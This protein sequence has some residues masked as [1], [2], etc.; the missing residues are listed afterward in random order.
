M[1][2]YRTP[3]LHQ[4]RREAALAEA[5]GFPLRPKRGVSRLSEDWNYSQG[6]FQRS[7]KE[8]RTSQYKGV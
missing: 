1:S 7:W 3:A 6:R 4:A 2:Y 8:H 5:D